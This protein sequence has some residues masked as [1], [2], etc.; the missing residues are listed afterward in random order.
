MQMNI[1]E[2]LQQKLG[3]E[4]AQASNE[5]IY[6]ALLSMVQEMAGE[7]ERTDSKK[8]LYYISAEFLIGKLLSNNMINLGIFNEIKDVL[9]QNGKNIA[10]IEEVEPE[11]SLGNGGLGRLAACFLDS[12]AT[13]GL[14]GDGVGLNY[15]LGLFKQ[16]FKNNLQRET[17]N[18]W[19]EAKSWLKKTDVVYPVS[20]KGLNVNA[21][22]YDI[23]VT[24]Y[25]NKT[26]KLHLF[27]IDS[28]D[29]TIVEDGI[30]FNK[31]DI[32]K[33]L[34]LFLYPD[35]SDENGRLLRI[36]QQYFMVSA[37]AQL[38]LDECTAKGCNLHDLADYAVIQINDTHPTMVIPELIRILVE[39]GLDMDEAIEVV[40]K[41]CAYTN[42]TILAEALEKWPVYYL[43]KVVPQLMPIIEVLDDK[44][45]RKYEDESVSIIDRNDT[46][47]MAHID[48]HYG[49]SVNG[50]ASLHTEILKETELN[51]FYK[52]Y[53]EKFNNK[54]NGITF[55]R[56]L[57][58]CNP[59]LTELLDELIGEGYKKDAAELEKLLAFK[60][61]DKVL[62]RLV[63]IKH[64]N[65]EALCKYLEETQGV[66][67]SPDT[68]FD[69]QIKRLHEYKRQ[70]LNA[71]YII[72]KY[73]EIKAGKIPAAPVTAIFGAKA[74]PAYVI[75]KDIIHL[76]LCLQEI[77]NNDPEVSP[78]LKVV[79][80]ENYNVTKAEKLIP[81]C[82][83][84]EQISLA[85][86]EASGTGNMKF[87]LNGAVTLGTEDGA[88]VEIHELV[89]NDNIFVFG[90]SSDEVIEHYA[91]A[92]YVARDFY[93]KNPA[94]KAA[95]DFITSEEV[96]KVGKKENLERLQHEIISKDWFMTLL[97]FDS[98]KEKKEEALRAYADQKTWAKKALVNI[99]K[100]G[101]FSSD[102]TIE[103]YNRDIWHL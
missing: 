25:N 53:P 21:R 102:R 59:T 51:N 66:K 73:L 76:I 90:A 48:I 3:K 38:I 82:D 27:D 31:E 67:V 9:A 77:I 69:I 4:I 71:L 1:Q 99:A 43:K 79:M 23:E 91:K 34:T 61:D 75:A 55:R 68:I 40:S 20:F 103:E 98:Y 87:M 65:K 45:R 84:S 46:V 7:K 49:F 12:I 10:E 39:R 30:T 50:V 47:H 63:E 33:N 97:D 56:W 96:L 95:I 42:H 70:Q 22:M 16:E 41:T 78:Y 37:G 93:E 92:D 36:Y 64:A 8:K 100:A 14:A 101:Y 15:H 35:D 2:T 54:T 72:D 17:P 52:I 74:A 19:I 85:S 5:E 89:G 94:I 13:L 32:E 44:V 58:H 86:K 80:V 29:E 6:G 81:A 24:G 62:D 11:P 88:N 18:P 60:D 57:L 83:I 26:N 28:V